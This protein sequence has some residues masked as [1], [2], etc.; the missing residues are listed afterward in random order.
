M[1]TRVE[2]VVLLDDDGRAIGTA[3]KADVHGPDTP[4]HLAFSCYVFDDEHRLLLTRRA[5][6]KVTWPGVWT[7]TCCGHPV[8]GEAFVD[9]VR[10]RTQQELGLA[11]DHLRL[12]LPEFRYR[13]EMADG[14]VENELCPVF[15]ATTSGPVRPDPAEVAEHRWEPWA[16]LRNDV[17]AGRADVSPWC[18]LQV[19]ALPEAPYDAAAADADLLPP[20]A[21][22]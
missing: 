18:V 21:R 20:A 1:S 3:P 22:S 16:A 5:W 14:T 10:R 6:H 7:N 13:V 19:A 17:I 12:V 9:A 2:E 11:L 4:L 15:V 8:P